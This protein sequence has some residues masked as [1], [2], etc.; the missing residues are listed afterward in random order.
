MPKWPQRSAIDIYNSAVFELQ[1]HDIESLV[2]TRRTIFRCTQKINEVIKKLDQAFISN[3]ASKNC[4]RFSI[5]TM[6]KRTINR[7]Y[8]TYIMDK[9]WADSKTIKLIKA[10][11][12][13]P[14][15]RKSFNRYGIQKAPTEKTRLENILGGPIMEI[16]RKWKTLRAYYNKL[17]TYTHAKRHQ[18][19]FFKEMSMTMAI[20]SDDTDEHSVQHHAMVCL[21]LLRIFLCSFVS[22]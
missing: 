1:P 9:V 21:D 17:L 4:I 14:V 22:Q 2:S 6:K 12:M 15:L 18:W 11:R 19:R 5:G 13:S 20:D 16:G 8:S 3:R 10:M 7:K